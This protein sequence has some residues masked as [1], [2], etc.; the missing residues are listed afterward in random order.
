MD[1]Y[2]NLIG[3]LGAGWTI[4]IPP[5]TMILDQVITYT[6]IAESD[7]TAFFYVTHHTYVW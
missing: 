3:Y 5:L 6:N 1:L 7:F 2:T 4:N